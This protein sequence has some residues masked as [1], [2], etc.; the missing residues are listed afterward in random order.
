MKQ[1]GNYKFLQKFSWYTP[2]IGGMFALLAW[3]LLGAAIGAILTLIVGSALGQD[4]VAKYGT[5]IS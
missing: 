3:M 4:A 1:R 2:G 5:L